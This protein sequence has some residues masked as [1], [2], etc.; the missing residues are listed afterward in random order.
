M[1]KF[2]VRMKIIHG[3]RLAIPAIVLLVAMTGIFQSSDCDARPRTAAKQVVPTYNLSFEELRN[4]VGARIAVHTTF[5]TKREGLLTRYTD[6]GITIKLDPDQGGF[7]LE[8]PRNTLLDATVITPAPPP[9]PSAQPPPAG[10]S[11]SAGTAIAEI[12]RDESLAKA[13]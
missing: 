5:G 6:V 13:Y 9:A 12:I 10:E 2:L 1:S 8:V 3:V 4:Q 11:A 7:D